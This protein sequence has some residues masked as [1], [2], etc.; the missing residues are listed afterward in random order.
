MAIREKIL[1]K[2][3]RQLLKLLNPRSKEFARNFPKADTRYPL[4][5]DEKRALGPSGAVLEYVQ[6][7]SFPIVEYTGLTLLPAIYIAN[8][9]EPEETS[10]RNSIL[11][12]SN[13]DSVFEV[14]PLTL[15]IVVH[16]EV[17]P[18]YEDS[19]P[20]R[21]A[22]IR[23]QLD[24]FLDMQAFGGIVDKR[25]GYKTPSRVYRALITTTQTLKGIASPWEIVDFDF[26]VIFQR[27]YARD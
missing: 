19:N 1:E 10:A 11:G 27:Q 20:V 16:Q 12:N 17:E 5:D 25:F 7:G 4:S 6:M 18:K 24:Y 8:G 3:Y 26:V 13:L 15:R 2:A 22:A 23:E 9:T 14:Y 21:L